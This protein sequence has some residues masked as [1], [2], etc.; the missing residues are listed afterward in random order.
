MFGVQVQ[1]LRDSL[2]QGQLGL[3]AD[4]LPVHCPEDEA[5]RPV[6]TAPLLISTQL[7]DSCHAN[8]ILFWYFL[9]ADR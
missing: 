7:P 8:T 1:C 5:S 4:E 9:L 6:H 3:E 2:P